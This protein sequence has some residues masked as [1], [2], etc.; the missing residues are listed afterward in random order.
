MDLA[1]P[2]DPPPWPRAG[3]GAAVRLVPITR[4]DFPLLKRWLDTPHVARWWNHDTDPAALEA[5]FGGCVDGTEP[6]EMFFAEAGA[7][8]FG[9]IQRFAFSA[10]PA[11]RDEVAPL[12]DVPPEGLSIDYFVGDP[13]AL[14][15]GWGA[16]MIRA[17]VASAWTRYP[18]APCV[19]V[20]V[21]ASN[22][23]S[24]RVLEAAGFRRVAE[25]PLEPDNP[26]DDWTHWLYRL[27]RPADT[28]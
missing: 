12:L 27:D 18:A 9:L 15:R 25:G 10:Y 24:W 11:Y 26:I 14:R 2:S 8:P 28:G 6:C 13:A 17:C 23:G 1:D 21:N 5:H 16:A 7:R 4:A 22:P 19:V 3:A 20:P